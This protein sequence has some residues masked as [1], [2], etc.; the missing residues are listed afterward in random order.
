[1]IGDFVTRALSILYL[2][3][4]LRI[5][6]LIGQLN[7][8]LLIPFGFVL[9]IGT[10]GIN[11][12]LTNEIVKN[13]G[14]PDKLKSAVI[15]NIFILFMLTLISFIILVFGAEFIVNLVASNSIDHMY[16]DALVRCTQFLAIGVIFYSINT[17]FR[18]YFIAKEDFTIVSL[19]YMSEQALKIVILFIGIFL[20]YLSDISITNSYVYILT[21]SILVSLIS[22]LALFT[23][24]F[25]KKGYQSVFK[26]GNYTYDN[27]YIKYII[28]ASIVIFASGSFAAIYDQIDMMLMNKLSLENSVEVFNEYF[29]SSMKLVLIPISMATGF[30]SVMITHIGST[31]EGDKKLEFDKMINVSLI[32]SILAVV[33]LTS[34][35]S[36]F[37]EFMYGYESIGIFKVQ[38]FIIPFYIIRNMLGTYVLTNN[39]KNYSIVLALVVGIALKIIL[40]VFFYNIIGINGF[41]FAS[42]ISIFTSIVMLVTFNTNLFMINRDTIMTKVKYVALALIALIIM[43]IVSSFTLYLFD[44]RVINIGITALIALAV[45]AILFIKE[46]KILGG[47]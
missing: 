32:Y 40:D 43:V 21:F 27:K 17:F 30:I 44:M 7:A 10:M 26:E 13:K 12:I 45:V 1:M 20:C 16:I 11:I 8:I 2:I 38:I 25:F 34:I 23:Y 35:C 3:P 15:S 39:G 33:V 6:P 19:S 22:T 24:S 28:I 4:L 46:I 9:T 18:A 14:N 29:T 42:I 31:S 36:V 5:D 37:Y 47:R 41:V